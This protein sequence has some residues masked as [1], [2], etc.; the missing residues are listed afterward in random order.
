MSVDLTAHVGATLDFLVIGAQ[1]SGTTSLWRHL[2]SHP[3]IY[4]PPSKE[5]PFFSHD[6]PFA[7]GLEWYLGEFFA[8][9]HPAQRW[10]T[11]S[12]HYMM[13]SPGVDVGEVARRIHSLLPQV[14]LIAVLRDPIERAQSHHRMVLHRGRETR[15]FDTA[16]R[17]LLVPEMLERA[18][19]E[20][21]LVQPYFV[22]GEYGRILGNYLALFGRE[23][24]HVL[25]TSDLRDDP[26]E[27]M[28]AIFAFLGVD[29]RHEPPEPMKRHHRGGRARRLDADAE[30]ALK[31]HLAR[32]VWPQMAHPAQQ[33]RAFN[34]WFMQWN[35][36]PEERLAPLD[37]ELRAQLQDH[38]ARDAELLESLTGLTVPWRRAAPTPY[39]APSPATAA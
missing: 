32:E 4:V 25:L 20:P 14:K 36:I 17:E 3:E 26:G 1:R 23:Q 15:D 33:Q 7:R 19:R 37:P 16:A 24:L 13:G 38:Y 27:A 22:Q 9:A 6:E 28:R 34:F 2:A 5:A 10:G 29:E 12:P 18:R 31:D 11:V 39:A 21:P 30:Q 35:V 8:E